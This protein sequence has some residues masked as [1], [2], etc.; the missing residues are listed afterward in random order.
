MSATTGRES[1][2]PARASI[3]LRRGPRAIFVAAAP[4]HPRPPVK[5][6]CHHRVQ[7][8]RPANICIPPNQNFTHVAS[9]FRA[10]Y[11][12]NLAHSMRSLF[13]RSTTL[14]SQQGLDPGTHFVLL[15]QAID[16]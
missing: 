14:H 16:G 9:F 5:P 7:P 4:R 11:V 3:R 2:V 10:P 8:A 12:D 6:S 13:A 1:A 15:R